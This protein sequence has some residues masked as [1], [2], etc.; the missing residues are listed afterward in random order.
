MHAHVTDA[1]ICLHWLQQVPECMRFKVA[2][3][4]NCSL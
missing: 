3:L 4:V 2:A 1:L